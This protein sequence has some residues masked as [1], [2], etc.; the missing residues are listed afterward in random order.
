MANPNEQK[1]LSEVFRELER[2]REKQVQMY[3]ENQKAK[4]ESSF[5]FHIKHRTKKD[6]I[7]LILIV[8]T[9]L[10]VFSLFS[11]NYIFAVSINESPKNV[12]GTFEKNDE[13]KDI[14]AILSRNMSNT[15]QKEIVDQEEDIEFEVEYIENKDMPEGETIDVQEG[16]LGK[17]VV[18][19]VNSYENDNMIEQ[20]SI[21]ER[22][23]QEAQNQ[24]I[25]V[26][27]SK[28][29]KQYNIHIGDNL[30]VSEDTELKKST[31]VDSDKWLI[32]PK[33]Y[34]VKTLEIIDEAWLKVSYNNKNTGYILTDYLTSETLTPGIAE[35]SRKAKILNK[36]DFNMAL[37]EPSGLTLDDYKKIL[38]TQE[39]DTN[40]V[41]KD[42]Y[43]AFYDVEQKYGINGVFVASIAIHE[44]G[45]GKSTIAMD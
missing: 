33:F 29:L 21:G 38:S 31:N 40:N 1:S 26:G 12:I 5:I 2:N 22:I 44:S 10:F 11:R 25:E 43:K 36:V 8:L 17:K 19:Y 9:I 41:F 37:N 3:Q 16:I 35:Y 28:V 15:E 39:R 42:N 23:I 45:W 32:I 24:I 30:Y 34:D 6:N 4:I 18:T 20:N 14:Y 27:T 13:P 7:L